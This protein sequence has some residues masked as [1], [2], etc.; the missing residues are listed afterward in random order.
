M[1]KK[2]L[3]EN[4]LSLK[5]RYNAVILA[6]LYQNSDVQDIAD[7]VG[8]SLELSRKAQAAEG[9]VIVF[10]G[11]RFMAETAKI[12]NP[13]K[14]VLLPDADAGCPM[15]DMISAED[16]VN[17]K[18]AHPNAAVICYVNSGA[19][20]KALSDISCTSSNAVKV[21][22]SIEE[23][24]IIFVPDKNLGRYVSTF[25]P[26]KRF[27]LFEGFCPTHNKI[28][29]SDLESVRAVRPNTPIL[30]HPE[31]LPEVVQKADFVGSTAQ[32]INYV[33]KSDKEEFVI[34]T[35]SGVIHSLSKLCPTKKF[36]S[37]GNAM[38]CPNM[39]KTTLESVYHALDKMQYKI[40]LDADIAKKASVSLNRMLSL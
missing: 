7:F 39:K 18:D 21:A 27:I 33:A 8:D 12:L 36:Y 28:K 40:E 15:A 22:A 32:I 37:L 26:D 14:T 1:D 24:E 19:E 9:D 6:H 3:I 38:I 29:L 11:V 4:I 5:E 16:L 30:V 2:V 20:I 23:K 17:L 10:C 34:G 31:C 13:G 35:E 25:F